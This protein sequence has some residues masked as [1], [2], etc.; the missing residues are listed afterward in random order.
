MSHF[1]LK[2]AILC[3]KNP[4]SMLLRFYVKSNYLGNFQNRMKILKNENMM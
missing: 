3:S 1:D 2:S 4:N